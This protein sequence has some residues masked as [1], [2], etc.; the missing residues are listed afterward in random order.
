VAARI[1]EFDAARLR[2]L[3]SATRY[4]SIPTY[5][6]LGDRGRLTEERTTDFAD[7]AA[8]DVEVT[9]KIDGTNARVVVPPAEWGAP[10]IG[11]RTE[12]LHH[13]G[14]VIF[15]PAQGIVDAVRGHAARMAA[16]L[17]EPDALVV[18][19]GEVFGGR[20]ASGAKNYSTTGTV[21]FRVFDIARVP[22]EVLDREP[23]QIAA[24]RDGGGQPFVPTAELHARVDDLGLDRVP[25]LTPDRPVPVTIAE[26]HDWLRGLLTETHARL[27][28]SGRGAPE[29]VVVRSVDRTRI[30]KIRFEDHERTAGPARR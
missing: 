28:D 15:N 5:H 18:V 25:V 29:G 10:L 30:A 2:A 22:P 17:A 13:L 8:A 24:W 6:A 12:L 21:G 11:S 19:F 20:T 26:T 4:P 16:A 1:P 9:E 7:L 23:E 27:D 3:N 14:D